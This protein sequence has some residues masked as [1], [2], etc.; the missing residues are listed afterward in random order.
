MIR[1]GSAIAAAA[2]LAACGGHGVV[3]QQNVVPSNG[4]SG[5]VSFDGLSPDAKTS[6]CDVKGM[7]YFH[8]NCV[9]FNMNI[10]SNTVVTLGKYKQYAGLKIVTT[11]SPFSNPPKVKT[12]P[13]VMGD[14]TGKKDDITGTVKRKA[15][16]LY[17]PGKQGCVNTQ[18]KPEICPGRATFVYAELI[19]KSSYT[20]KPKN[21]P[22]FYITDQNGFPGKNLCFPAILTSKGWAPNET[23]GGKPSGNTLRIGSTKN[24][25]ELI[26]PANGQFI[27]VGV[28]Q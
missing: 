1:F 28:C 26:F 20:L 27:V 5:D 19:N 23:L 21:T 6:P 16:P 12:V 17:V 22:S 24:P 14:A 10:N 9:A 3:P 11:L 8:G 13:A 4:A 25:G 7:Y 15:F 2:L 18:N